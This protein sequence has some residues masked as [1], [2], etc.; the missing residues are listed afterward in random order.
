[1]YSMLL[2]DN[3]VEIVWVIM[4]MLYGDKLKEQCLYLLL[5]M[6]LLTFNNSNYSYNNNNINNVINQSKNNVRYG[7][8]RSVLTDEGSD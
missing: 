8:I 2:S 4:V 1:M 7:T 3:Y 6:K 5:N